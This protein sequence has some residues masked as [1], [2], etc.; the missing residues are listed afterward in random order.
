MSTVAKEN[1]SKEKIF[2]ECTMCGKRWA[3]KDEF[4]SDAEVH[5]NGYQWNKKRLR[6]GEDICGLLIFTHAKESCYTTLGIEAQRFR[7][8][9]AGKNNGRKKAT[10]A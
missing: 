2:K 3:S 7:V 10:P 8:E 9:G 6:S 4:L 5:L 1:P